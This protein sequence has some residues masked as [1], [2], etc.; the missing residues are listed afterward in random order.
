MQETARRIVAGD[1]LFPGDGQVRSNTHST[2]AGAPVTGITDLG[3]SFDRTTT[4]WHHNIISDCEQTLGRRLTEGE[5]RFVISR[6][7]FVALEMIHDEVKS[8]AAKPDDLV[9]YLNSEA[10]TPSKNQKNKC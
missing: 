10:G 6:G 1:Q 2:L 9:S 3:M 4:R 5:R 7:G 8:L